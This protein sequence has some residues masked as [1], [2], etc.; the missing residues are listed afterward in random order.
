MWWSIGLNLSMDRF[1]V[2]VVAADVASVRQVLVDPTVA[3]EGVLTTFWLDLCR[4]EWV[5]GVLI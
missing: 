2:V 4:I 3:V 1:V 5:L